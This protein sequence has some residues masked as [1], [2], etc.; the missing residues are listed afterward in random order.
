M[1]WKGKAIAILSED[2]CE[3]PELW[4]ILWRAILA[5]DDAQHAPF[6]GPVAHGQVQG[7]EHER[8]WQTVGSSASLGR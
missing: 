6:L 7:V 5:S 2:Y 3:D 8:S 4:E 1:Q